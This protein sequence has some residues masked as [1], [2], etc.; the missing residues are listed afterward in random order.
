MPSS[1]VALSL[2][3]AFAFTVLITNSS[4]FRKLLCLDLKIQRNLKTTPQ[5]GTAYFELPQPTNWPVNKHKE[6]NSEPFKK[7]L[8]NYGLLHFPVK[9][10][11]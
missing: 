6:Q 10:K 5:N 3:I 1:V 8:L 2:R 4:E 11:K 9:H 7:I